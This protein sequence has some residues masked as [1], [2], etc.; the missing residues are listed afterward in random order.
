MKRFKTKSNAGWLILLSF[1]LVFSS[2]SSKTEELLKN[3]PFDAQVVG[4]LNL[5]EL[6]SE[7]GVTVS[8]GHLQLPNEFSMLKENISQSDLD[9]MSDIA[10]AV[11]LEHIVFFGYVKREMAFAT[12]YLKDAD[13]LRSLLKAEGFDRQLDKGREIFAKGD[14]GP[15]LAM[16]DEENQIW[17]VANRGNLSELENF[18]FARKKNNIT[19]YSGLTEALTKDAVANVVVDQ[20]AVQLGLDDYWTATSLSVNNNTIVLTAKSIT[21]AGEE[22]HSDALTKVDTDFLRYIPANFIGAM[23]IGVN[24]NSQWLKPL[25]AVVQQNGSNNDRAVF[26]EM[27]PYLKSIDG[28]VAFAFGPKTKG[29][30]LKPENPQEWQ[31]LLMAHMSQSKV[32]DLTET[33][34]SYLPGSTAVSNGLYNFNS[35]ELDLTYGAVNGYFAI[36]WGLDLK[37]DKSNSFTNDFNGKPFGLVLQ[38]PML[39]SLVDDSRLAYSVKAAMEMNGNTL[40]IQLNLVGSD[41]PII[42]TL[43]STL[44]VFAEKYQQKVRSLYQAQ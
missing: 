18:E 21:N 20:S 10:E 12:T 32:N 22:Y 24:G 15:C 36:G 44:P 30:L 17:F 26:N 23:A 4:T 7:S 8:D 31:A 43:V 40:T 27:L 14:Y 28:T 41:S 29:S 42:P 37:P 2:C 34:R 5:V 11:D 9:K 16:D 19:R 3:V 13:K 1:I 39:N 35:Q 38:T 33:M 6:A 25:E